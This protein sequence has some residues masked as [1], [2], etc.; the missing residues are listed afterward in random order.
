MWLHLAPREWRGALPF[1]IGLYFFLTLTGFLITRILL[2]DKAQGEATGSTWRG[3]AYVLFQKR[4]ALRILIPCYAAML[5]AILVGAPDIREHPFFYF[6]HTVNFHIALMPGWP[7]GTAHYWTLAIQQQFYLLWPLLIYLTPRRLLLPVLLFVVALAPI[8]RAVILHHFPQVL[9]P[10]VISSCALDY[11]GAGALLAWAMDRGMK[12]GDRRLAIAS[13]IAFVPYVV[14]YVLDETGH[15]VPVVR[16]IQQTL[17]SL[18][19][20]GLISATLEGFSGPLGKLLEHPAIQHVG[21]I[22]YGL[23][24]FHTA[25]PLFLGFVMPFLWW[26]SVPQGARIAAIFLASWGTAWLCWRYLE[27]GLDRFRQSKRAT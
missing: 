1:E 6:T 2:R 17:V 20:A 3:A 8:S 12:A 13:W 14:L 7:S 19:F 18:M 23:Y 10:G 16:H 27:Q 4:R 24:L 26:P 5:F 21:K 22:S 11:L 9:H 15:T 25:I